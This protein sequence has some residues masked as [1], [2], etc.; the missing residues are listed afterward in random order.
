MNHFQA[1]LMVLSQKVD[2]NVVRKAIQLK[3]FEKKQ[4]GDFNILN[5]R[6]V[7]LEWVTMYE[8]SKAGFLLVTLNFELE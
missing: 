3:Y 2:S 5:F 6:H 4:N 1:R 7:S 8:K